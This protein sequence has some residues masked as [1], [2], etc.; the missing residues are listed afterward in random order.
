[1]NHGEQVADPFENPTGASLPPMPGGA[2]AAGAPP[3]GGLHSAAPYGGYNHYG[4]SPYA[5]GQSG[6][7]SG[8]GSGMYGGGGGVYPAYNP[9]YAGVGYAGAPARG[10]PFAVSAGQAQSGGAAVLSG[11][12]EAMQ[13]FAR[14]S[15]LLEETLRNL[16]LLFDGVFGLG[17]SLGAFYDEAR[18]WLAVKTG[19][20]AFLVRVAKKLAKLWRL[21]ALFLVSPLAGEFSPVG[22][23]LRMLGIVPAEENPGVAD[24]IFDG[25]GENERHGFP[26]GTGLFRTDSNM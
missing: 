19:P 16:H 2:Q 23:V 14:V 18:L 15:G 25:R 20:A 11:M 4:A 24:D 5:A 3:V 1:M 12:Q 10:G 22:L 8:Y 17:Y 9:P 26:G 6:Y 7:G 21:L 13:R